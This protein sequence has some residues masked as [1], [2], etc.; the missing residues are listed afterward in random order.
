MST[1]LD[2]ASE[3]RG[4]RKWRLG[5][6]MLEVPAEH[7][8]AVAEAIG[9]AKGNARSYW[10]TA[11]AWPPDARGTSAAWTV[12]RDLAKD[13][14]RFD[15]IK[16]G[17]T[18]RSLYEAKTG[19]QIDRRATHNLPDDDLIDEVVK[20]MLSPR[21]ASLVPRI[22]SRLNTSKEGRK[23]A[24]DRRSTHALRRLDDEIRQVQKEIRRLQSDKSPRT[25]FVEV[26][27][28]LLETEVNVEE[29]GL[30]ANDPDDRQFADDEDW[31]DLATR[32]SE[33]A[34]T[35]SRVAASILDRTEAVEADGWLAADDLW[36]VRELSS[37][38]AYAV[39]AEIVDAD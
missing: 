8:D 19:R 33:L 13:D 9:L 24:R 31:R 18:V 28:R 5:D 39:D 29:I 34:D 27:K 37:S 1:P 21:R 16:P 11:E 4:V 7:R 23:A 3:R 38:H 10:R 6:A 15:L 2:P 12:Y 30:L 26:R 25:R 20:L 35:A 17:M 36:S 22:L 14:D 32:V